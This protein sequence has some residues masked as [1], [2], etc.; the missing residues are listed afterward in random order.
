RLAAGLDIPGEDLGLGRDRVGSAA[1]GDAGSTEERAADRRQR[2]DGLVL[3]D[4]AV[5]LMGPRREVVDGQRPAMLAIAGR[6]P[7]VELV[8]HVEQRGGTIL[9]LVL[10]LEQNLW[11]DVFLPRHGRV[12][13]HEPAGRI[14]AHVEP[15]VAPGPPLGLA[16]PAMLR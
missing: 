1:A 8:G 13:L 9:L 3:D 6:R 4:M 2:R 14:G 7:D 16:E 10:K 12:V 5:D 11:I 15:A